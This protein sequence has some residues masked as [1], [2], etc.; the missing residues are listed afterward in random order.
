MIKKKYDHFKMYM[1]MSRA[2]VPAL[3]M[4]TYYAERIMYA[5]RTRVEEKRVSL[6]HVRRGLQQ[7]SL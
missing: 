7:R 5:K 4:A 6:R 2:G 1:N 3:H